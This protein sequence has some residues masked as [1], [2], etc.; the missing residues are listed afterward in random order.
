MPIAFRCPSCSRGLLVPDQAVGKRAKCPGCGTL[1]VVPAASSDLETPA[2]TPPVA[3]PSGTPEPPPSAH[4]GAAPPVGLPWERERKSVVSF[5]N[6]AQL[7]VLKPQIA[8]QQ[9]HREG[10]AAPLA[11]AIC[12]EVCSALI[13]L[14]LG[15]LVSAASALGIAGGH[16]AKFDVGVFLVDDLFPAF[17]FC[18][19]LMGGRM[20][21]MLIVGSLIH[22]LLL[23]FRGASYS[24]VTTLRVVGYVGGV[25]ALLGAI[26]CLGFQLAPVGFAVYAVLGLS[27]AHETTKGKATGA[28]LVA[29]VILGFVLWAALL[30][31]FLFG[32]HMAA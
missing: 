9:M 11:F 10:L 15:C 17:R 26:P 18:G 16:A 7:I 12:G 23:G 1:V 32:P 3:P 29:L 8:F 21:G 19:L 30:C 25:L 24:I 28:V 20:I 4:V 13:L 27:A 6:T 31:Y 22:V 5:W 2:S 14:V